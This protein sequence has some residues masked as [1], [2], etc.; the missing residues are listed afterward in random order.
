MRPR[1][2]PDQSFAL[3]GE[4][5]GSLIAQGFAYL[6]PDLVD[7]LLL[8]TPGGSPTADASRLPVHQTLVADP[9]LRSELHEDELDSYDTFLVVQNRDIVE[10]RRRV[11]QPPQALHDPDQAARVWQA[12]DY[13]F[14]FQ[15]PEAVFA[16]PTLIVSGRQDSWSGYADAI[17]W[18]PTYPRA[19][20]A[21]LDTAGHALVLERPQL[22]AALAQDWLIRLSQPA[23]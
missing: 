15:S 16:K 10:K 7:G 12:F 22:F 2:S 1:P 21:V 9:A 4:S 18:L 8:I 20:F 11:I 19:T 5:R 3:I 13:P 6:R 14:D 23:A 17:D